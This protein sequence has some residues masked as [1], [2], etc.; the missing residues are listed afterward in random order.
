MSTCLGG[1]RLLEP[2][3]IPSSVSKD[4]SSFR[5]AAGEALAHEM[6]SARRRVRA[7]FDN[8]EVVGLARV[9]QFDGIQIEHRNPR[10]FGLAPP[11]ALFPLLAVLVRP[12]MRCNAPPSFVHRV[13]HRTNKA[14]S[15]SALLADLPEIRPPL[16]TQANPSAYSRCRCS[17]NVFGL[18]QTVLRFDTNAL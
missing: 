17:T 18:P 12:R 2:H 15:D 11:R 4:A 9:P 10:E 16:A 14:S 8:L 3:I 13:F 7:Y 6:F 1:S 5:F